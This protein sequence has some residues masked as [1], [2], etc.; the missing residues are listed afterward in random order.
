MQVYRNDYIYIRAKYNNEKQI[1]SKYVKAIYNSALMSHFIHYT[2]RHYL[3]DFYDTIALLSFTWRDS[4]EQAISHSVYYR[5]I[6][7]L[8]TRSQV[9]NYVRNSDAINREAL[10]DDGATLKFI[11]NVIYYLLLVILVAYFFQ[12]SKSMFSRYSNVSNDI[13][14]RCQLT[15]SL[16]LFCEDTAEIAY[17]DSLKRSSNSV[18]DV[19]IRFY[20]FN[21]S[22]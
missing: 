1:W 18:S 22:L 4:S 11:T 16:R 3:L 17:F 10:I 7:A 13:F 5:I 20:S 15:F 21:A 9:F 19:F 14:P 6:V 2:S 12:S 8:E